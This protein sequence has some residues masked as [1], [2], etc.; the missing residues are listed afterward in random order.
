M[1]MSLATA[2]S[3]VASAVFLIRLLPQPARLWRTGVTAG[4]SPIAAANAVT[5]ASAWTVYGL[6]RGLFVVWLVSFFA[7]V[8]G[9]WT[10]VLLR[11]RFGRRELFLA[12]VM[13]SAY[14]L[15]GVLG[16]LGAAI[17]LS[18]LAT[19]G[20]QVWR[21]IRESDLRGIAAATWFVAIADATLWGA[22]GIVISDR[23]LQG[24]AVVLLTSAAI[25]LGRIAWTNRRY[26][27][28]ADP[29]P[30]VSVA[31]G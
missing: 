7:L 15:A 19:S 21:A 2:L 10:V 22:Y 17:A 27:H 14:V 4:V 25:V 8:P 5:A 6:V 12:A 3:I 31:A 16:V 11:R 1:L 13:P 29:H 20:P 30:V 9:V 24:Y 18:V 28:A 26:D 23:A